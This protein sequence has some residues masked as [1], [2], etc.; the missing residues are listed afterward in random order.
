M[1]QGLPKKIE[2]QLLLADLAFQFGDAPAGEIKFV[3]WHLERPARS[4]GG[5]RFALARPAQRT[6]G[7]LT[8]GAKQISPSVEILP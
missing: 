7:C 4:R 1:P 2:F 6:Q 3:G 5:C 8:A